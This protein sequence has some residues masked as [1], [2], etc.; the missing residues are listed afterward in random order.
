MR[1]L[2]QSKPINPRYIN[3]FIPTGW[4]YLFEV[5]TEWAQEVCDFS[6]DDQKNIRLLE[7]KKRCEHTLQKV[8]ATI[9]SGND[10]QIRAARNREARE[11]LE[12]SLHRA[13]AEIAERKIEI[14]QSQKRLGAFQKQVLFF[15]NSIRQQ[16]AEGMYKAQLTTPSGLILDI[17]TTFFRRNDIHEMWRK[18]VGFAMARDITGYGQSKADGLVL[19]NIDDLEKLKAILLET[20]RGGGHSQKAHLRRELANWM[21]IEL[22]KLPKSLS[23]DAIFELAKECFKDHPGN[24]SKS[25][26]R[27]VWKKEAPPER[28]EPGAKPKKSPEK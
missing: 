19:A 1:E 14:E 15:Q 11:S 22:P 13:T 24:I 17:D 8:P 6:E 18:G 2:F 3:L 20:P 26:F 23:F 21:K 27:E 25:L 5:P 12:N 28:K 4:R 10:W 7:Q 16:Y 9:I